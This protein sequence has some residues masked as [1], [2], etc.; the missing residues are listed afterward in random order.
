MIKSGRH[1]V[2]AGLGL[3]AAFCCSAAW[4]D[5]APPNAERLAE[6]RAGRLDTARADWWGFDSE[7]STAMLQAAVTSGVRKLT[8]PNLGRPWIVSPVKLSS[9]I[10]IDVEPG[11]VVEA[12]RGGFKDPTDSLFKAIGQ[13]NIVFRGGA[14]SVFRMH[15][16]DYQN[17][18]LYKRGEWRHILCF[19]SC[20]NVQVEG[21]TLKSSGGDGIYVAGRPSERIPLC[22]NVVVK[23]CIIDDNHRQGISVIC[24][25]NMLIE[26]CLIKNTDGTPPQA[27]IDFEGRPFQDV[28]VRN[29]TFENN[30]A[31]VIIMTWISTNSPLT[32]F[33]FADCVAVSNRGIGFAATFGTS[34][35]PMHLVR[36]RMTNTVEI[37]RRGEVRR[38][39]DFWRDLTRMQALTPAEADQV[40]RIAKWDLDARPVKPLRNATLPKLPPGVKTP[41]VKL[42]GIRGKSTW[43]LHAAAGETVAFKAEF[44]PVG[45][46]DKQMKVKLSGPAGEAI[47]LAQPVV[48]MQPEVFTFTAP[49]TGTHRIALDPGNAMG[50]V[51]GEAKKPDAVS[52]EDAV[53]VAKTISLIADERPLHF[54]GAQSLFYFH[55]PAGVREF[56][57]L[58]AGSGAERVKATLY[59]AQSEVVEVADNVSL[60]KRMFVTRDDASRGEVWMLQTSM[61]GHYGIEDYEIDLFGVPPILSTTRE[62][63]YGE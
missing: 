41:A 50:W 25:T 51:A 16:K 45:S 2:I 28:T 44:R 11:T 20:E 38:Y 34:E 56:Y 21:L 15:K 13:S 8:I 22:R 1:S 17:P 6:I 31:G 3:L 7:D 58:A 42:P 39:D 49:A 57:V 26:G 60:A 30:Y 46:G 48:G 27:G 24:V 54:M 59:N 14:G 47:P 61:P 29:C 32:S 62:G 35:P 43:V 12:I 36:C 10:A 4:A 18:A 19:I 37:T 9:N 40:Q 52:L 23:D 55:V 63:L 33:T 53:A 5:V